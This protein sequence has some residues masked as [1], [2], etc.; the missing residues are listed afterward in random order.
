MDRSRG[1]S[2]A[3]YVLDALRIVDFSTHQ[4]FYRMQE[5]FI[6]CPSLR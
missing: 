6:V 2:V 1:L 3:V 4:N 5:A